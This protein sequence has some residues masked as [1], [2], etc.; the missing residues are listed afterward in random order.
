MCDIFERGRVQD[1]ACTSASVNVSGYM[2]DTNASKHRQK[3]V[4]AMM[5]FP[6]LM[7]IVCRVACSIRTVT[8]VST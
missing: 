5:Q 1:A 8:H 6:I 4:L 7:T 3:A 2:H